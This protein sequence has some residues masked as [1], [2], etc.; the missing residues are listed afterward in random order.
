MCLISSASFTSKLGLLHDVLETG[1]NNVSFPY[2]H[3][4]NTIFVFAWG[5]VE[6]VLSDFHIVIR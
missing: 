4:L 1:A 2:V 3:I 6:T 5:R